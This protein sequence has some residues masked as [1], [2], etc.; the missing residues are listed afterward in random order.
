MLTRLPFGD[1]YCVWTEPN[2]LSLLPHFRA[3]TLRGGSHFGGWFPLRGGSLRTAAFLLQLLRA[4][5]SDIRDPTLEKLE[6]ARGAESKS[7]Q[8]LDALKSSLLAFSSP[9]NALRLS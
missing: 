7:P 4:R 5:G 2:F 6:A 8:P 3:A 9:W 1:C